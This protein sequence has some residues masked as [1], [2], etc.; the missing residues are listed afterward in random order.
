MPPNHG[1]RSRPPSSPNGH[2]TDGSGAAPTQFVS[3]YLVSPAYDIIFF[4]SSP[5]LA[6]ILGLGLSHSP[7]NR[8]EV[9]G[10]E[11]WVEMFLSI[12]VMAHLFIVIFRSHFNPGI[13]R[14][15]P[16]R[17]AIV[18]LVLFLAMG[19]S[20]WA[21]V[22]GS[23]LATF[24]DV[25]HSSLQTFGLGR[26]YDKIAGN[27]PRV[28]RRLDIALNLYIYAGPIA[29]GATLMDHVDDFAEFKAV[30]SLFF[31]EIPAYVEFNSAILTWLVIGTGV[32]FLFYY[33]HAYRKLA[34]AG[35]RVS[36][37]KVALLLSTGIVSIYAWGFN[38][39]GMAFFIMN[40]FHAWQYFAIIWW[41]ERDHLIRAVR[42][43]GR[44]RA[45]PAALALLLGTSLAYGLVAGL[46]HG[47]NDWLFSVF[48]VVSLMHFW[49]DGF[50]WSVRRHQI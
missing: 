27:D 33:L 16:V 11:N 40:V 26:L 12:F 47:G 29:A 38:P 25:Y 4:I 46:Y 23:V 39:F 13:Y 42:Q 7:L 50:I 22:I 43:E 1:D 14:L 35:H 45:V 30:N 2:G 18:P 37:Q 8:G 49:Y 24:W 6:L 20:I 21:M 41:S 5:L 36:F 44:T 48:L 31:T 9:L 17:F 28:G 34:R 32:P 10:G 19:Y 15:Y 3:H